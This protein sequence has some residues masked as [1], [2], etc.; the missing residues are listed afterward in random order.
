[1]WRSKLGALAAKQQ[2]VREDRP[3]WGAEMLLARVGV[4]VLWSLAPAQPCGCLA[5][6]GEQS[7]PDPWHPVCSPCRP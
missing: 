3:F 5:W 2:R 4:G 7:C 1:M 6:K